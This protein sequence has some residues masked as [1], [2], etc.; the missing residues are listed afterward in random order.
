MFM[1]GQE[2]TQEQ[3]RAAHERRLEGHNL[4]SAED[5]EAYQAGEPMRQHASVGWIGHRDGHYDSMV[6]DFVLHLSWSFSKIVRPSVDRDLCVRL[7][8][9]ISAK[10]SRRVR[11]S[12]WSAT[13]SIGRRLQN[14][15]RIVDKY[16][17]YDWKERRHLEPVRPIGKCKSCRDA[18]RQ[19]DQLDIEDAIAE[20]P[21]TAYGKQGSN[22]YYRKTDDEGGWEPFLTVV[23]VDYFGEGRL[24]KG[25]YLKVGEMDGKLRGSRIS[26]S[27]WGTVSHYGQEEDQEAARELGIW[28]KAS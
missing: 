15:V 14:H 2:L 11:P 12:R 6:D 20:V 4:I 25:E 9:S 10:T 8:V 19:A 21:A 22:C 24:P 18:M 13:V 7:N 23:S 1:Y 16:P 26:R 28:W 3:L 27:Y 17:P 5:A